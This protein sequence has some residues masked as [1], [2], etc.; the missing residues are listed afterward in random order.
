MTSDQ[1]NADPPESPVDA[2]TALTLEAFADTIVPGQPRWPGD[3]AVAGAAPGPS[4]AEA[5]A[6]A[7]LLMP[8]S[9][10]AAGLPDFA[11][12][13]N[14]S[15]Q[16]YAAA[17]DITLDPSLPA[18]PAMSFADRTAHAAQILTVGDPIRDFMMLLAS[19]ACWTFDMACHE[20]TADAAASGHAGLA[21]IGFP[22]PGP[23]GT[24]QFPEFSYGRQ[25]A[26]L[27][28]ATTPSGSPA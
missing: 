16:Q 18:F 10:I 2:A 25:L 8:E 3:V 11:Q 4:A 14:D 23:D 5:G 20:H 27:S 21:W 7:T 15:A 6:L 22:A 9:G 13:I 26:A 28:P 12:M 17:N 1:A 19:F 24:W